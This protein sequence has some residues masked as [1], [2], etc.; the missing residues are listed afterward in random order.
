MSLCDWNAYSMSFQFRNNSTLNENNLFRL[1]VYLVLNKRMND[2]PWVNLNFRNMLVFKLKHIQETEIKRIVTTQIPTLKE[3]QRF[4]LWLDVSIK[5]TNV[6]SR[7]QVNRFMV[8]PRCRVTPDTVAKLVRFQNH[9]YG[10]LFLTDKVGPK[11]LPTL[12]PLGDTLS[13]YMDKY[14]NRRRTL[15]VGDSDEVFCNLP[16]GSNWPTGSSGEVADF[17]EELTH[18]RIK[19]RYLRNIMLNSFAVT[20]SYNQKLI[21]YISAL[22]R[23]DEA[24]IAKHY[25]PSN[26]I[27]AET[28]WHHEP[29]LVKLNHRTTKK[30]GLLGIIKVWNFEDGETFGPPY[31]LMG[32]EETKKTGKRKQRVIEPVMAH[33]PREKKNIVIV[34]VDASPLC[35][36]ICVLMREGRMVI[37]YWCDIM[38]EVKNSNIHHY[39]SVDSLMSILDT[40]DARNTLVSVE[41]PLDQSINVNGKQSRYTRNIKARILSKL[42]RVCDAGPMLVKK[43]WNV[44][45]KGNDKKTGYLNWQQRGFPKI[46]HMKHSLLTHPVSDIVDATAIAHYTREVWRLEPGVKYM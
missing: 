29:E 30:D 33:F 7:Q 15:L 37:H 5:I 16:T 28:R 31:P 10:R 46:M 32:N 39:N 12:V 18:V 14:L 41:A 42:P 19:A 2:D 43:Y 26:R 23:N 21:H 34:G 45:P 17:V 8:M 1:G 9:L 35:V 36:A 24:T 11:T 22:T 13:F 6:A 27:Y 25:I 4:R 38:L 20:H 3:M 44:N 40:L